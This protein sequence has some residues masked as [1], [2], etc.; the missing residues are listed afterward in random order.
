MRN[1]EEVICRSKL[2][3]E[4]VCMMS[5]HGSVHR[6]ITI[7]DGIISTRHRVDG[8]GAVKDEEGGSMYLNTPFSLKTFD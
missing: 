1:R 8:R 5:L 3:N 2:P 6:G 7:D 4:V